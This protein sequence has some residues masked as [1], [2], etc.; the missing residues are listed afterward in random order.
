MPKITLSI[1]G[2]PP[3][4]VD[5]AAGENLYRALAAHH[6]MDAPCG[7]MGKCGKCR[8]RLPEAPPSPLAEEVHFFTAEELAAGWRLACLHTVECDTAAEL[9]AQEAVGDIVS[10]GLTRPAEGQPVV[11]KERTAHGTFLLRGGEKVLTEPGDTAA[12]LYGVAVDIGTTTVVAALIDLYTGQ[13]LASASCINSQSVY[14]QD[15]MSRIQHAGRPGGGTDL[16]N[17][18]LNDLRALLAHLYTHSE[19]GPDDVYEIAVAANNTMIHLLLGADPSG[20]GRTPY[21]PALCGPQTRT[22]AELGLPASPACLVFC[23]PAVSAF[24]GGDITAGVLACGLDRTDKTVLFIDIGTNGE[25]VLSRGGSLF[26]CSCAA[27]PALEGMNIRCGMRA[28]AGAVEDVQLSERDGTL[29]PALSVIGQSAPRGLC[30]S[31]LL[32]AIA[33]LRARQ[34]IQ[35]NGRLGA[36]P[37][38]EIAGGKKRV[39]LDAPSGLVLTQND[40]RQVQLAKGALLSGIRTMMRFAGIGPPDIDEMLVAG[41]FGAHL[42]VGSLVGAGIIPAAL[43]PAVRY[44]GNTSKSGAEL[45]LLS[46]DERRRAEEIAGRVRYVELS[47]LDGYEKV[48]VQSMRFEEE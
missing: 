37:L 39:V 42:K 1:P 9:P 40:I 30:G 31:G 13:E 29:V 35:P 12:R 19:A 41:Q 38:V 36:H 26:A 16:Q 5:C 7:G 45:C 43:G 33:Q 47:A 14:G 17:A 34:I 11:C 46:R 23:L 8:V 21:R 25:I 28:A 10:S 2:R 20:M 6:L 18:I 27:G 15:V 22:A 4:S 44:V 24:V 32:A 3:Q 48:F